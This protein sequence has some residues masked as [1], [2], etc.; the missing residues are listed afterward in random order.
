MDNEL[1]GRWA[2]GIRGIAIVVALTMVL[3]VL[4]YPWLHAYLVS[5]VAPWLGTIGAVGG[6]AAAAALVLWRR[7]GRRLVEWIMK[8]SPRTFLWVVC[9][10]SFILRWVILRVVDALPGREAPDIFGSW[11]FLSLIH[12]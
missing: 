7:P 2:A 6:L 11:V 5:W 12:I 1:P 10:A 4:I 9:T 3:A 8:S